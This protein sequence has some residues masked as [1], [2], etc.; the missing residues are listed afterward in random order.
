MTDKLQTLIDAHRYGV[1]QAKYHYGDMA[2]DTVESLEEL[3]V[4][5][6]EK[7]GFDNVR[8]E[9][10]A[11]LPEEDELSEIIDALRDGLD[12]NKDGLLQR[13]HEV[14]DMLESKQAVLSGQTDYAL[15]LL[16]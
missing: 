14:L 4:L 5:L 10:A 1:S 15:S 3:Q 9:I 2:A 13:V 16:G 11:Q 12:M 7:S 8:G 6:G